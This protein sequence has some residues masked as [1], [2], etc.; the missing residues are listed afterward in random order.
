[1]TTSEVR[2]RLE[3]LGHPV[4]SHAS[5]VDGEVARLFLRVVRPPRPAVRPSARQ[6]RAQL[7]DQARAH[8]PA[9]VRALLLTVAGTAV[10]LLAPFPLKVLADDVLAAGTVPEAIAW[11]PG[12]DGPAGAAAWLALATLLLVLLGDLLEAGVAM[13]T[14]AVSQHLA[15]GVG[16]SVLTRLLRRSPLARARDAV[17]DDLGR[18]MID[19]YGL[20]G[21]LLNTTVVP[22]QLLLSVVAA[23]AVMWVFD[24]VLAAVAVA[25]VGV[26]AAA[27][28]LYGRAVRRAAVRSR[29]AES[30]LQAHVHQLVSGVSVVQAFVQEKREARRFQRHA[31]MAVSAHQRT[32]VATGLS[33]LAPTLAG[34]VGLGLLLYVG[35]SR[36]L[37][38]QLTVG[39]L[40]VFLAYLKRMQDQ[41]TALTRLVAQVNRA[42]AGVERVLE[43]LDVEPEVSDRPSARR[44]EDVRGHL[45]IEDVSFGYEPGRPVLDGVTLEIRPGETLALVGP[46]GAGKSTLLSLVP[47]LADPSSG[48]VLLDGQDLRALRLEDVR[49]SMSVVLQEPLLFPISIAD[50]IAFGCPDADRS[51][52]EQAAREANA[53]AFIG[54]LRHGYDTVVGERGTTLSGGQRQRIAIARALLKD[55]PVLLLDEPTSALDN[56]SERLLLEALRRLMVGRTTLIIAHR[57]STTRHA[58]HIAVLEGGRVVE[59]GTH[60]ELVAAK[61]HYDRLQRAARRRPRRA[62]H[63]RAASPPV[64]AAQPSPAP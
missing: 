4:S 35:A 57:M 60:A 48:R 3:Q 55:A 59:A 2:H 40:L 15:Y 28:F 53:D 18:V 33:T 12:A 11:L 10:A 50:N 5:T 39:A 37:A 36:V 46:S 62:R 27:S 14:V 24:G 56:T 45:V 21:M 8:R 49:A 63:P 23:A 31:D 38:G 13:R 22:A 61:G 19:P 64:T 44:L 34:A 6:A 42:R 30:R 43:V 7:Y 47:R 58:H 32:A 9:L 29:E 54:R 16:R 20:P 41:A 26:Q 52:V 51:L 25:I 1:M 17:G